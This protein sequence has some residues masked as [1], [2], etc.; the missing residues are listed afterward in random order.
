MSDRTIRVLTWNVHGCVGRDGVRDPNR[1]ARVLEAA[2]PD[3]SALQEI[4]SR[5][6]AAAQD[7]FSYFGEL[8]GWTSVAARTLAAKD[9]HYG[10][11]VLSRWPIESLGEVDLSVR[12]REPR[13]A[14]VGAIASPVG[15]IVIVALHL[16]LSPFERRSQYAR[17]KERLGAIADRPL[18]VL[19]DFNDF[20]GRGLAEK[21]LGELLHGA[22]PMPTY[23]SRLPLLPL[24]RIWFSEPLELVTIAAL[25]DAERVSDHLPLLASLS[26]PP[27]AP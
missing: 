6:S 26:L 16:G 22:P 19:G 20:P 21:N 5:T 24:D 17:L 11:I 23:P 10:H 8:F 27:A 12:R 3:I 14:I 13:K 4:D 7:P 15:R 1:V 18:I 9:G 2:Q 25:R